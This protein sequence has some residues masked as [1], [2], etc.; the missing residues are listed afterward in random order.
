VGQQR[1]ASTIQTL[2]VKSIEIVIDPS[3]ETYRLELDETSG[4][5]IC[6]GHAS[7]V[8]KPTSA[9]KSA[10]HLRLPPWYVRTLRVIFQLYGRRYAHCARTGHAGHYTEMD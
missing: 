4:N 6:F 3:A 2:A 7:H 8:L 9:M 10:A 1:N 5:E